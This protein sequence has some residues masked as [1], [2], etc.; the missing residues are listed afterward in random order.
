MAEYAEQNLFAPLGIDSHKWYAFPNVADMTVASSALYLRPRDMA[1]IG[2]MCLDG[3]VWN[4]T[5][6]VSKGW[7]SLSTQEAVG[8][9][10]SDSPF[11]NLN[12]AYGFLWWLGTFSTGDTQSYFAAGWGGQFIF[13]LPELE[14]VVVF[15]GGG[16]EDRDYEPVVQIMNQHVLPAVER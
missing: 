3:G 15:T 7:V 5:R 1:K 9:V 4:G 16:F 8:M 11:P 6:I 10:A 13:V 14:M 2:Q 12:T